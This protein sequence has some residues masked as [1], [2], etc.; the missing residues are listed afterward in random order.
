MNDASGHLP[1][2][3]DAPIVPSEWGLLD[4][5]AQHRGLP[6]HL[7]DPHEQERRQASGAGDMVKLVFVLDPPPAIGPNAER[8]W[9]EVLAPPRRG[10][11]R[12][13]PHQPAHG[14]PRP[15]RPLL[16]RVRPPARGRHRPAR[17]EV[18]FDVDQHAVV[19]TRRAL[20]RAVPPGW[21]VHDEPVDGIDSGW[22]VC[23]GD[24]P[25]DHFSGD[26][27]PPPRP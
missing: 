18:A 2:T 27:E 10:H 20:A 22:T 1:M 21:V 15:G 24:E 12:G 5:E 23:A 3:D 4:A 13:L 14:H 7:P 26:P 8:M 25:A 9:V 6:R 11:L 19:S 17:H 16:R